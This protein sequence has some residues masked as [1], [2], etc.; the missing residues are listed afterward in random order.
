MSQE[1]LSHLIGK[2]KAQAARKFEREIREL[3]ADITD[4]T[5]KNERLKTALEQEMKRNL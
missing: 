1:H 5:L 4:L 2:A 3:T